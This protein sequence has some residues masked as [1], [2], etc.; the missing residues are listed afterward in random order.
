MNT[1]E[2]IQLYILNYFWVKL[3]KMLHLL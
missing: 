3:G 1:E 2:C